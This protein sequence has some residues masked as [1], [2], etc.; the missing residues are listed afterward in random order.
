M[1]RND[2]I[3]LR[4]LST[5]ISLILIAVVF[6]ARDMPHAGLLVFGVGLACGL[7]VGVTVI[8]WQKQLHWIDGKV[9]PGPVELKLNDPKLEQ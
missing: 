4:V 7:S 8:V 5:A 1:E 6:G 3:T 2:A 9:Y